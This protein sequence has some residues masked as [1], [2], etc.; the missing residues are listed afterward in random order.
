MPCSDVANILFY[1]HLLRAQS[2]SVTLWTVADQTPLSMASPGKNTAV[3]RPA[4]LQESVMSPALVLP[5]R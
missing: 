1:F 2:N 5:P 3:D 4:C